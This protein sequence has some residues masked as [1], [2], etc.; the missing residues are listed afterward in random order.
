MP[1]NLIFKAVKPTNKPFYHDRFDKK[2]FSWGSRI[3]RAFRGDFASGLWRSGLLKSVEDFLF[4][5][6]HLSTKKQEL[7]IPLIQLGLLTYLKNRQ[8]IINNLDTCLFADAFGSSLLRKSTAGQRRK[9]TV[10]V[11]I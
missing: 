2:R 5:D 4:S 10:I 7:L 3:S 9:I 6:Y 11:K 8:K 1:C